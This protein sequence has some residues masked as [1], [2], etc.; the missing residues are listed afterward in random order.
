[1][2]DSSDTPR[3]TRRR[4]LLT[5]GAAA[6]LATVAGAAVIQ[7]EM[8]WEPGTADRPAATDGP[9]GGAVAW[10]FFNAAEAAFVEAAVAQLIP[11]DELGPGAVEVG[12]PAFIDRQLG[13]DYGSGARWYMQGP[14]AEGESTQ[15]YQSRL[16]PAGLYRL[17]IR[18]IDAAVAR[19][20]GAPA[21]ARLASADRDT[22]LHRMEDG[23]LELP[24]ADAKAFFQLLHQ[25]T[26]EG[27][28]ADPVY[29]GN[30]DMAGWTL[31]GFPGARYDHRDFVTRHG[32]AYPLP[33]VGL[34]GRPQWLRQ[35]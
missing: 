31:I 3:L 22:W 34:M 30:R 24:T 13:G 9:Q 32:E 28:W 6:P 8:P 16:T 14:W 23:K 29:G 21:F 20:G 26:L 1:M 12:V 18:E 2:A 19:E 17:A 4:L 15:G 10:Q 35:E 33:P 27:F 7:R 11:R 5:A 25:N